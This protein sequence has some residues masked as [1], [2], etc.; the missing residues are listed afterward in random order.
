MTKV[1]AINGSPRK[2][3]NTSILIRLIL[4]ELEKEGIE[5]ETIQLGGKKIHGC[6]SCM[7]CFENRDRKCVIADDLVNTCI[8]KMS[9]ADGII[10]GSPVYFLDLTPEMKALIDRAGF[11][12]FANGHLF[13]N[14]VGNAAVAVRRTGA[15]R[16]ADSMLHFF[17]ANEMIVPGLPVIGIGRDIGDV[18]QDDEG[19]ARAKK[20][21]QTMARLLN[22]LSRYPLPAEKPAPADD[23]MTKKKK[24]E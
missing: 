11:V 1:L 10:F 15:S 17:L 21:G 3:G 14:K 5:T 7:K 9:N 8:E 18:R 20:I 16:T 2:D 23:R 4:T 24:R 13:R 19:I 22:H 6:T 12:S